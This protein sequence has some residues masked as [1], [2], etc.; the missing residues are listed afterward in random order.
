MTFAS[1]SRLALLSFALTASAC[2]LI[3]PDHPTEFRDPDTGAS[4]AGIGDSVDA[5]ADDAADDG[6][7]ESGYDAPLDGTTESGP[8]APLDGTTESG[9]DAPLDGTTDAMP[10]P[11]I[12][13]IPDLVLW[14]RGDRG[15]RLD[16]S[17]VQGWADQSGNGNDFTASPNRPL[18]VN[19]GISA[20]SF[21]G[22]TQ[23]LFRMSA[24]GIR[25]GGA[26]TLVVLARLTS[27]VNRTPLLVQTSPNELAA[28]AYA[29]EA[30]TARSQGN[31]FGAFVNAYSFDSNQST[32]TTRYGVH[33]LR[34]DSLRWPDVIQDYLSYRLNGVAAT[35]TVNAGPGVSLKAPAPIETLV[36]AFDIGGG[37]Y[38]YGA[39]DIAEVAIYSRA[40]SDAEIA[41][42]EGDLKSRYGL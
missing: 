25:A 35:L 32:N 36:G 30:N 18:P 6:A 10:E 24:L 22:A 23:F 20:V 26:R 5:M 29:I 41:R 3:V 7:T 4:D 38:L 14:L 2:G 37:S 33:V 39:S 11:V 42:V 1:R 27:T 8:D 13:S 16:A 12:G 15:V 40:L 34:A 28:D 19:D 31:L 17:G 9:P 21:D